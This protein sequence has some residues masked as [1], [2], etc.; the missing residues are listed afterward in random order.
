M[1][2]PT[3]AATMHPLIGRAGWLAIGELDVQVE[4]IDVRQR[5]GRADYLVT[6][7]RGHGQQW[8]SADSV[9][10]TEEI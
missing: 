3:T 2:E 5:F 10:V 9:R 7:T 1:T 4:I 6:P 8:K